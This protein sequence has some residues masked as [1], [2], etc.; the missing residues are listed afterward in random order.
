MI[1]GVETEAEAADGLSTRELRVRP[2]RADVAKVLRAEGRVVVAKERGAL[3]GAHRWAE[4]RR[5]AMTRLIKKECDLRRA[6]IVGVLNEL[7]QDA[8]A[9]R[10]Q[11]EDVVQPRCERLVLAKCLHILL[12]ERECVGIARDEPPAQRLCSK[13]LRHLM[14]HVKVHAARAR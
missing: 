10:I 8:R 12:A 14:R 2:N 5:V 9:V 3:P 11:L 7:M 6:R 4:E 13:T 1:D